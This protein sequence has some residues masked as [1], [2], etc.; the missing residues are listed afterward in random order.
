MRRP[1][2]TPRFH[3]LPA[4]SMRRRRTKWWRSAPVAGRWPWGP[5]RWIVS[6]R[7]PEPRPHRAD[8]AVRRHPA[9]G[10]CTFAPPPR[11]VAWHAPRHRHPPDAAARG[12]ER[13]ARADGAVVRN[14]PGF[15]RR[16]SRGHSP[17]LPRRTPMGRTRSR[18][19]CTESNARL[20]GS[21]GT[22]PAVPTSRRT[23]RPRA[24]GASRPTGRSQVATSPDPRRVLVLRP[25]T[26]A[27]RHTWLA[28]RS[29]DPHRLCP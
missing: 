23:A 20:P 21:S 27:G 11:A 12:R 25:V 1:A 7:A 10:G 6:P 17:G 8:A 18:T 14:V 5:A 26:G 3:A 29:V 2:H 24:R 28:W 19:G 4:G 15:P 9:T 22:R 16:W 13:R